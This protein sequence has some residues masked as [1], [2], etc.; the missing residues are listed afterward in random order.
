MHKQKLKR[1]GPQST[2]TIHNPAN[3]GTSQA[4][5]PLL[6]DNDCQ[7]NSSSPVSMLKDNLPDD[8]GDIRKNLMAMI[9][10]EAN[11]EQCFSLLRDMELVD[12]DGQFAYDNEEADESLLDG[13]EVE[14]KIEQEAPE[15]MTSDAPPVVQQKKW[16]PVFGTRQSDRTQNHGKT[17]LELAQEKQMI[18]NL[19][20]PPPSRNQVPLQRSVGEK[21]GASAKH[22]KFF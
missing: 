21:K 5:L 10:A 22:A 12:E 6:A 13:E 16:G 20:K 2:R 1:S 3:S 7:V 8:V 15:K 4:Q 11:E 19:E 18:K 17:I 9:T 14:E